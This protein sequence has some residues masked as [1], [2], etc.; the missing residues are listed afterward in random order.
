MKF[1]RTGPQAL[2][3]LLPALILLLDPAQLPA[4]AVH[5]LAVSS[6]LTYAAAAS[7]AFKEVTS[8]LDSLDRER[9]EISIRQAVEGISA[10]PAVQPAVRRQISLRTF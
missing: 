8:K 1:A 9:L 10:S 4:S 5:S 3:V 6:L 7:G 2:G